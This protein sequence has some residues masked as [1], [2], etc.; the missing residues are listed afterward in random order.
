MFALADCNNFFVSCERVFNPSLNGKPVVVLSNND[1][2]VISRS[3]E[4]KAL[5]IP[6]GCPAFQLGNYTDAR[7]VIMLSANHVLYSDLSHRI[8]SIIGS[9]VD[10]LEIYSVDEAFFHVPFDD[11]DKN[12]EFL[13]ALRRRILKCVG[14][15]VSIGFAATHSL[16]KIAS[17]VA[18]K[19]PS[20]TDGVYWLTSQ[21]AINDI[22]ARTPV[23]D[24]W[25]IGRRLN[26]SLTAR[27]VLTAADF[28]ALSPSMVRKFYSITC[29][30][31]LLEL[32]GENCQIVN[33]V[34]IAH[35]TIMNSRTFGHVIYKKSEIRDAIV[36]FAQM[37]AKRL[38]D[39]HAVA[40][41]VSVYVR[42]DYNRE[43]L[44]FYTN[45][46]QMRITTPTS[47]TLAIVHYTLLA[48]DNI[49]RDGYAYRKAGV[50]VSDIATDSSVQLGLFDGFDNGKHAQLMKAIDHINNMYGSACVK[51]VP[52]S[53][54]G[55]WSP[56]RRHFL[57]TNSPL[58]FFSAMVE[59]IKN[60]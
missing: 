36:V 34:T 35:K 37:C 50:C 40:S 27:G 21:D 57:K 41:S 43:D 18:K 58:R 19:D 54:D 13:A 51:L 20:V 9:V 5:G 30:R 17:H 38:R 33:P 10:G 32:R 56:V 25:G 23:G 4:A 7:K 11:D 1:G 47:S 2:C 14:V 60:K 3:N 39:E 24:V 26:E 8:M 52:G 48:F 46:C 16:A 12:H 28:A 44:P 42:G 15:P 29:V 53:Q 49:F 6:M 55:E 31:T 59:D 45:S 22:L